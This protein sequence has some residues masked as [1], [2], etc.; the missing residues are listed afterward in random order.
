MSGASASSRLGDI[1]QLRSRPLP[2]TPTRATRLCGWPEGTISAAAAAQ[3]LASRPPAASRLTCP[4]LTAAGCPKQGH[5]RKRRGGRGLMQL[6]RQG[7]RPRVT[8]RTLRL[9]VLGA[10]ELEGDHDLG[11][12]TEQSEEADPDQQQRSLYRE[13][14]LGGPEAEQDLQDAG[15]HAQPPGAVDLP[16][17]GGCDDV[18]RAPEDEQQPQDR[19]ER[20]ERVIA[21]GES[22]AGAEG[23]DD[24]H[25]DVQP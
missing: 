4:R 1:F 5:T 11:D 24:A 23:K 12:A 7:P 6:M 25:H 20:A 3:A 16:G 14:L 18:E 9:G 19:G 15:H 13:V 22:P 2:F 10:A 8:P 21:L 17:A